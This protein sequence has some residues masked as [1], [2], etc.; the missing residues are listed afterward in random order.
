MLLAGCCSC[1]SG[2]GDSGKSHC[3][4]KAART[5]ACPTEPSLSVYCCNNDSD[6][7]HSQDK[8]AAK[9][10]PSGLQ[11]NKSRTVCIAANNAM[12]N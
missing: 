1:G 5:A 3:D 6:G 12:A 11:W 8:S 9:W 4:G 7:S 10:F 2:G